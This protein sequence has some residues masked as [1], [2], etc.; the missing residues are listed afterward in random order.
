MRKHA[1]YEG[2][3]LT[4]YARTRRAGIASISML[5]AVCILSGCSGDA[6]P[7]KTTESTG[8]YEVL[9][10]RY[11][12]SPSNISTPE[13]AEDLG[14]LAPLKLKWIGNSTSGPESIQATA[15]G[16]TDF[17]SAFNGAV[18]KLVAAK[19]PIKTVMSSGGIDANTW[20][21]YYVLDDSPIKT[22]RDLLGKKIGLNT[23]GAHHEFMIREF[24]TRHGLTKEE[25]QQVTLVVTPP[26]SGE[27][28]LRQR[29]L[30]VTTLGGVLKEKALE[31]GGIHPLFSDRQL[32][33]DFSTSSTVMRTDFI[34]KNP[35]TT[36]KFIAAC[37]KALEWL[38][39]TPREE[40]IARFEKISK[41]R[42]TTDDISALK[43][44]KSTGVASKGGLVAEKDF[45]VWV[46]WLVREGEL[47]TGQWKATDFYT[48]A[49]NPFLDE[50]KQ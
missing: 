5:A 28:A 22:A 10:L 7:G 25:I 19:A 31:R 27:Q 38:K 46:D 11:L 24:L 17:G 2:A 43:Y 41:A 12:G 39:T 44:W 14:Y 3:A 36:R 50:S 18:V 13:V 15:T 34:Q 6:A 40:V 29:Q 35:H 9:E 20:N 8:E 30:D 23:L 1:L 33:G 48:N 21:G 4:P 45:T 32:F 16:N 47:K 42:N 37:A 49:F 26:L